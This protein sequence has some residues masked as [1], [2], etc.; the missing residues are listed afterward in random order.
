[1]ENFLKPYISD[2]S[3]DLYN[4]YKNGSS[5]LFEG[6]QGISLDVDHGVYPHTTSSNTIAGHISSGTGI[7]FRKIDRVIG[8]TKA[9]LSRVG[10]SPLP[11]ELEGDE[12]TALRDKGR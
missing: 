6:A 4:S 5:I 9:Y 3:V 1:M 8:V 7:T 12:A 2:I 11:T 10:Q